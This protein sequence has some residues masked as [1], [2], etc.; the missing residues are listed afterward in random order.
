MCPAFKK[1]GIFHYFNFYLCTLRMYG[2]HIGKKL[3]GK[4]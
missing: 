2:G 1:R 3:F 4:L